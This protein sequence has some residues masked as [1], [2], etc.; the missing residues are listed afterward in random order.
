MSHFTVMVIG[1]NPE[2]QLAPYD[3]N[4]ETVPRRKEISGDSIEQMAKYYGIDPTDLSSLCKHMRDWDGCA[5]V[6]EDDKLYKLSTYNENSK[7]DW[8]QL[9]GRWSGYLKMKVSGTGEYGQQSWTNE[10]QPTDPLYADAALKKDIDF[11][12]MRDEAEARDLA[13]WEKAQALLAGKTFEPWKMVLARHGTNT[14][15]ARTEYHTQEGRIALH[16]DHDFSWDCD[17]VLRTRDEVIRHARRDA[18]CAFALVKNGEWFERGEMGWWAC[19][20]NEKNA[21]VWAEKVEKLLD[22]LPDDTLISI[23]DCH[24]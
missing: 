21:D 2:Q 12:G 13:R 15:A 4:I 23:Y 24:I 5:G 1:D 17:D 9:G 8:Y 16:A 3:E 22:G 14:E 19:V 7:W 10:G 11:D 20:N 6:V 18:I